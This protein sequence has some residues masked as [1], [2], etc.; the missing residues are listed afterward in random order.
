MSDDKKVIFSMVKVNK[1][2]PT[3][4]HILKDIYLSFYYGAK[5]GILGLNGS[6]KSTVMKIIAGLDKAYQGDVVWAPGYTVGY[7]PQETFLPKNTK[8]K[9]VIPMYFPKDERQDNVFYAPGINRIE[10]KSIKNL[11]FGE[12]RYFELVSY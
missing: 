1:T 10:N 4:Q 7:L 11:S 5:I 3:G 9:N 6:G 12:L 2:T 8:V